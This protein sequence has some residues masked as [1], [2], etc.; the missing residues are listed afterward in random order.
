MNDAE[1]HERDRVGAAADQ[2]RDREAD[3]RRRR[4]VPA[5]EQ[6]PGQHDRRDDER[7]GQPGRD[8]ALGQ[9]RSASAGSA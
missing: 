2:A 9:R 8:Q 7:G 3:D 4:I 5:A 1:G 6:E